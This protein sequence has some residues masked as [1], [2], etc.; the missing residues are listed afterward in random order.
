LLKS[1]SS[2]SVREVGSFHSLLIVVFLCFLVKYG[3]LLDSFTCRLVFF[4][5]NMG[6]CTIIALIL[7]ILDLFI[8]GLDVY[9]SIIFLRSLRL[10]EFLKTWALFPIDQRIS[11]LNSVNYFDKYC[12]AVIE[13]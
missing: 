2:V 1:G 9:F 7:P 11:V 10:F 4:L 8:L 3:F 5:I 6:S 12:E 13:T